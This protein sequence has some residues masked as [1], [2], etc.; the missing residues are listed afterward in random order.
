MPRKRSSWGRNWPDRARKRALKPASIR[1]KLR[2]RSRS[3][4]SPIYVRKKAAISWDGVFTETESPRTLPGN[5]ASLD[6]RL[7][8][9]GKRGQLNF[10]GERLLDRLRVSRLRVTS[11]S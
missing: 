6:K 7:T 4:P 11:P 2:S 9:A 5:Q 10:L 1:P 8:G 3:R